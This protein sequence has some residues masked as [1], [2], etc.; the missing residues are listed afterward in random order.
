MRRVALI[1]TPQPIHPHL[2]FDTYQ[3][4]VCV[5]ANPVLSS[6]LRPYCQGPSIMLP[7][8]RNKVDIS[9]GTLSIPYQTSHLRLHICMRDGEN[10]SMWKA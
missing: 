7:A 9:V 5:K 1:E 3:P 10:P 6:E 2:T 4:V 8:R